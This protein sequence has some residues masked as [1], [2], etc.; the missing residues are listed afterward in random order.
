MLEQLNIYQIKDNVL[1]A[2]KALGWQE[3]K[4][5]RMNR[6]IPSYEFQIKP[7]GTLELYARI[8]TNGISK[9]PIDIYLKDDFSSLVR[10]TFLIWGSFVGILIAMA[11]YNLVLF[12]GLKDRVYL[13]YTGYITSVLM[14]LGVVIGFGHYIWPESIIR[15]LRESIVAVNILSLIHI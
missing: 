3:T 8:A 9:T 1:V 13:V 5:S 6:S 12:F 11:L 4:L 2:E 14:M 10:F 7:H 15:F